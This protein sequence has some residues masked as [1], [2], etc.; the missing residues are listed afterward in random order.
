MNH[1]DDL[2]RRKD[3]QDAILKSTQLTHQIAFI[4]AIPAVRTEEV[5]RGI[6]GVIEVDGQI[7]IEE[8]SFKDNYG[9]RPVLPLPPNFSIL[10]DRKI[11]AYI[12][13]KKEE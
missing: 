10:K 2:I 1:P 7:D 8:W 6:K 13:K 11:V 3:A 9:S 4:D 5:L 12:V